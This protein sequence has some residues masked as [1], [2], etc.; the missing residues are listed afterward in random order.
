[1]PGTVLVRLGSRRKLWRI[2]SSSSSTGECPV[3]GPW[4]CRARRGATTG[5]LVQT[6]LK[7]VWRS[8]VQFGHGV[9]SARRGATTGVLVQTVP[10]TV[11]RSAVQFGHGVGVPVVVQRQVFWSRQC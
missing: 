9:V 1:M 2:R 11:W 6:V 3:V 10:E 8:A 4:W 5:V 7:T